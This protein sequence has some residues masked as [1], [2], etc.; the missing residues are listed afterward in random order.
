MQ[1]P[2]LSEIVIIFGLSILVLFICYRLRVPT[3]VGFLLT[4]IIA[5]PHG[6]GLI[7]AVHE[8]E[9]LAEIGVVLLL[10][11]IGIEFSLKS[12]VQVRRSVLLGGSLQVLLTIIVAL[13]IARLFGQSFGESVF[14]GFLVSLS[15]TAIVLKL[16]QER[17]EVDSPH[18]RTSLAILI[19]QDVIVVPMMLLTPLLG[20]AT[21]NVGKSLLFLLAK[22]IGV[23]V[24]V[25]I[26]AHWI[27]PRLLYQIARTRSR[28]LFILSIVVMCFAVAWLTSSIGL[29]LALGAFLAGLII[30]ESEYSHQALSNILPFRDV[31]TS[32]F[33]IS[34][35][36]LLDLAFVLK[37]PLLISLMALGVLFVKTITGSFA[38]A[39]LGFPLRTTIL[40][41]LILS[42]VGEFSFI[43][44]RTGLEYNL[45]DGNIYQTFLS[46]SVLTMAA[47]PFIVALAPHI[48]DSISQLPLPERIK[49]GLYPSP[50][51]NIADKKE[52]LK[53]HLIII[54][55]GVNGRNVARAARV[56][57]IPYLIIEMNPDTVRSE[58]EKGELIYYGDAVQEAVL[59]RAGINDARVLVVAI[60]DPAATRQVTA[61][62]R[63]LN[64]KVYVIARTRFVQE[65]KP[66][67]ELG[68]SEVIP[69]EF[70]TSVEIFTRV[71]TKYLVPRDVIEKFIAEVRS[72]GYEMFR[73]PSKSSPFLSDLALHIPEIEICSL[74]VHEGSSIVGKSLAEIELRNRYGVT[75]LAIRR[76]SEILPN[77]DR[78]IKFLPNDAL[79]VLG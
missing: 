28:E 62:A 69:E 60:S 48:A 42:Q 37:H 29:S 63:R 6:L 47:A 61:I 20:G 74:Q 8:V 50:G 5:G 76:D 9:T 22:G 65:V 45:L 54:G 57:G 34:I 36:M 14:I 40:V 56:A 43:L 49:S 75:L 53:D 27:V 18:G 13:V 12:L 68:A 30:S 23:I 11:T 15:S 7:K 33:F 66:L 79:I 3:I 35:G 55:F 25:L 31:F 44:S 41:G 77:P 78:D 38:S 32:F 72:D 16:I 10:F 70:E 71:L 73:S 58:Q 59:E 19:F 24:V 52:S 4:G 51:I 64:P 17:A 1:I 46:V 26:S 21:G 2:L 67:Y 39:L